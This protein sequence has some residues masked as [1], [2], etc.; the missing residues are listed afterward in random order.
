M[1]EMEKNL[2]IAKPAPKK[3]VPPIKPDFAQGKN[4]GGGA[5]ETKR[6]TEAEFEALSQS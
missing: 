5:G 3:P 1:A 4:V 6:L 2:G